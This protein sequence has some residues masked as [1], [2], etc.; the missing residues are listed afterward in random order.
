[1][2]E[3]RDKITAQVPM[4]EV[5][6]VQLLQ[7]MIGDLSNAPEPI[8]IKLFSEDPA[9][10]RE[11]A[12]RV[13]QAIEKLPGVVDVMDGIENTIS[14]PAITFQVDPAV[15]ARAGFT[16]E[17]IEQTAA[18]MLQGEP[19]STSGGSERP[20]LSHSRPV[21][22]GGARLAGRDSQHPGRQRQR[23]DR[24]PWLAG[25]PYG[26]A[27]PNGDPPRE[28]SVRGRRHRPPGGSEPGHRYGC[29]AEGGGRPEPASG[30]PRHLRREPSK[31]S[32]A[33]SATCPSC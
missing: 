8:I 26:T 27:G 20:G 10:R 9:L 32:S 13:A 2:S 17:E 31:S 1:M 3:V 16:P 24:D 25:P 7:D 23:Q 18:A 21:W 22:T 6:F 5:E 29:G 11:W 4:L 15:T 30:D 28:S 14:G 33:P 19:A 12:P